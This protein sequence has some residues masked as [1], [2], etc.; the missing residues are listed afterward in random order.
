MMCHWLTCRS[1][2]QSLQRTS[3]LPSRSP[4]TIDCHDVPGGTAR[5]RVK[6]TLQEH[7]TRLGLAN[8]KMEAMGVD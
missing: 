7:R 1:C 4:R 8:M 3:S 6:S 2:L 5:D